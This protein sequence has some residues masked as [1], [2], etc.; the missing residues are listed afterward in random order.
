MPSGELSTT[1]IVQDALTKGK[2][3]FIPYIYTVEP[4]AMLPKT[5]VMDMLALESVEEFKSLE[6]DKW[7][8]PSLKNDQVHSK[9]NC[10]GGTGLTFP[11]E[12]QT[13]SH[14]SQGM[15]L[16]VMPGMAFDQDFR[17]LGHGKGYYDHFLTRYSTKAADGKTVAGAP[18]MPFLGKKTSCAVVWNN[19]YQRKTSKNRHKTPSDSTLSQLPSPSRNKCFPRP[20]KSPLH[21]MT[22]LSMPSLSVMESSSSANA[23]TTRKT[24]SF[25]VD[26]F[27]SYVYMMCF[28]RPPPT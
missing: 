27:P 3:V 22:G 1:S 17:R 25:R 11:A 6:A 16:I 24:E 2:E 14:D 5:S 12:E 19:S 7:G 18:K 28:D 23:D 13:T 9:K 8:I 15:D 26:S 4:P 10:F 21:I 20:K